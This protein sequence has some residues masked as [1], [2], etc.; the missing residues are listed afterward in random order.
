MLKTIVN[1]ING[2][3][4]SKKGF[5]SR[6]KFSLGYRVGQYKTLC[7]VRW[8]EV[9]R[10]VFICS[11]NICRSPLAAVQAQVLGIDATSY[12]LHCTDGHPADPRAIAFGHSHDLELDLH[13]TR[14]IKHYQPKA[15]D[16]LIGMEPR[17]AE[18]LISIYGVNNPPITVAGVWLD[19]PNPYIH[20]PFSSP[21]EYFARCELEVIRAVR[22]IKKK[23]GAH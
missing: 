8:S 11:G 21:P 18:E 9:E 14:H 16:L 2:R 22:N 23:M 15:G 10:L 12:G 3:Y 19:S 17:H 6:V 20:D 5:L 13:R 7:S 1:Y 4:G